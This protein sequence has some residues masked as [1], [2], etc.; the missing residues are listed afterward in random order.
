[1]VLVTNPFYNSRIWHHL[2][3]S[4][5]I[6]WHLRSA[7]ILK[8]NWIVKNKGTSTLHSLCSTLFYKGNPESIGYSLNS[9][10][11]ERSAC[12]GRGRP[13][14]F[15]NKLSTDWR[16]HLASDNNTIGISDFY[17]KC[18]PLI[19]CDLC[20]CYYFLSLQQHLRLLKENGYFNSAFKSRQPFIHQ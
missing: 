5:T 17:Q 7:P 10:K 20:R 14:S 19:S 16:G 3:S 4:C 9:H 18:P 2:T 1:M 8:V 11:M 6:F 15:L 13:W 12:E